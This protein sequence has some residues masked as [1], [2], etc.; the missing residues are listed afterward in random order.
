MPFLGPTLLTRI[1]K[2]VDEKAFTEFIL[3]KQLKLL[4]EE[5]KKYLHHFP[6]IKIEIVNLT[7]F[8]LFQ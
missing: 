6:H 1:I 3:N 5:W 8:Y 4:V 2:A 7:F